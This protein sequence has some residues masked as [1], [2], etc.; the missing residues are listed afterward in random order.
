MTNS[1][2]LAEQDTSILSAP[3]LPG[4]DR[5]GSVKWSTETLKKQTRYPDPGH[6]EVWGPA[7]PS[8]VESALSVLE[9]WLI[10]PRDRSTCSHNSCQALPVNLLNQMSRL[11]SSH[12]FGVPWHMKTMDNQVIN[13]W[14]LSRW[15]SQGEELFMLATIIERI[16]ACH[17][18]KQRIIS[19]WKIIE[20]K[21]KSVS[22]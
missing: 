20:W 11:L 5:R 12:Y 21:Y 16:F 1:R 8:R 4:F 18:K 22:T 3:F 9:L 14:P 10:Y 2:G 6:N 19:W 13:A 17:D 15:K 7:N